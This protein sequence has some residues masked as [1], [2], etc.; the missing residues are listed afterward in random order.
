MAVNVLI[1]YTI[2]ENLCDSRYY[3]EDCESN[4]QNYMEN[5]ELKISDEVRHLVKL[6]K[7]QATPPVSPNTAKT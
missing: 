4:S 1:Q 3:L 2:I 5:H 6:A 7:T